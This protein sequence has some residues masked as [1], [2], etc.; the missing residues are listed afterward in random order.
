MSPDRHSR[1]SCPSPTDRPRD[2]DYD[3]K[4][5][6]T[7]SRRSNRCFLPGAPPT[8]WSCCWTTWVSAPPARSVGRAH[9]DRGA[10]GLRR[11][12]V[13]PV[14]HH[15]ALRPDPAGDAH[16]PQSPLG[17]DG[18]HHRDRH[19]G[20]GEQLA[21]AEPESAAGDDAEAE[22][23]LHR[24]VRQV[25]RGARVADLSDGPFDAWPSGGGGSRR[26]TGSWAV[27]TT[28]SDRALYDGT[29]PVE[30]PGH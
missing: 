26:S 21:A 7:R 24:P 4:D 19:V 2:D 22:R 17:G 9:P 18:Q 10:A 5:P 20:A 14:P 8:C 16:R 11:S 23:L 25:P 12:E 30:P 15:G 13:Q 28:R 27:R 29:T 3:A 1:A 6:D